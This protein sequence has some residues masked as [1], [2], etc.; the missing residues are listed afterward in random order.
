MALV[1][2]PRKAAVNR[3]QIQVLLVEDEEAHA[4]LIQ[5]AFEPQEE[6]MSLTVAGTL[7]EARRVLTQAPP[8]L[9]LVDLLLPDGRGIELLP[10]EGET[11]G[12]PFVVMTSHGDEKV[13]VE[14]LKAGALHYVVKSV[15]T[16][17]DMPQIVERALRE[18]GHVVE[19]QRAEEA[20]QASEAHFRSLIENALDIIFEVDPDGTIH[21]TSPSIERV[22]G[23]SPSERIGTNM[24]ELI[25]PEDRTEIIG[26]LLDT[27]DE[28]GTTHSM[29]YRHRHKDGSVRILEAIASAHRQIRAPRR[30]VINAR[31]ITDR[32]QAEKAQKRLQDQL[33]HSQKWEVV[34]TL[35]GGIANEFNNMLTPILG[36]ATLALEETSAESRIHK[37]LR[38]ILTAANRSKDLA[39]QLLVF[40]RQAEPLREAVYLHEVV[41]EALKLMRPTLPP[42]IEIR[43]RIDTECDPV[44]ADTDQIRQVLVNL[45][46]HAY[47]AMPEGGELGVE[48]AMVEVNPEYIAEHGHPRE[49]GPFV[50]L[51]VSDTGQGMDAD[52]RER[53]LEPFA[54]G[55]DGLEAGL[56]LAVTHGIVVSHGGEL[57]VESEPEKGN[58][59]HVYLPRSRAEAR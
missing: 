40:S 15:A 18:W 36:F 47:H 43:Q 52:L 23:Y 48:V 49:E 3:T 14:A 37:R 30:A 17:S 32:K 41:D 10:G 25:H 57:V 59:I 54:G 12:L 33:R 34:G 29:E 44:M 46:T 45:C 26:Q 13:A 50:R 56:G 24:F 22:L 31:D 7:A 19:R 1:T 16:L 42:T 21:Y 39:E 27:F 53:M 55:S 35:A 20:L 6:L 9:V 11:A 51:T 28:P 38:H 8:D 2:D 4:E 58:R 5:R